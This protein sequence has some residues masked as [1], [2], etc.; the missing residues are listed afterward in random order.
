VEEEIEYLEERNL[1]MAKLDLLLSRKRL[2]EAAFLHFEEGRY[3]AAF[4]LFFEDGKVDHTL[5][6]KAK[7]CVMQGL[8]QTLGFGSNV[9]D[10]SVETMAY[11]HLDCLHRLAPETLSEKELNEV[12]IHFL[13]LWASMI[14]FFTFRLKCS[15]RYCGS[16]LIGSLSFQAHS[17]A[18]KT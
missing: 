18:R 10:K 14:S 15:E 2:R 3:L 1:D 12:N 5:M 13:Y 17:D 11:D 9:T 6:L 4:P 8:W 7:D 16:T